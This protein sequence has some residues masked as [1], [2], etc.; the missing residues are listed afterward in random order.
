MSFTRR[1]SLPARSSS[2]GGFTL[3][4]L[5][6]VIGIIALLAGVALG[7]ITGAM[8]T[9]KDNA[10]MQTTHSLYLADFQYSVDNAT[11]GQ[12]ADAADAGFIAQALLNGGYIQD[13]TI[14]YLSGGNAQKWQTAGAA[15]G[16]TKAFV[17]WD[18]MGVNGPAAGGTTPD[19]GVG[20][21]DPDQLPLIWST[22]N[23]INI[24]TG[25]GGVA[26][27]AVVNGAG[28]NPLGTDGI[29]VVFK[30]GSSVFKK[31]TLIG[32]PPTIATFIDA[33]FV[34]A[35]ATNYVVRDGSE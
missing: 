35:N 24:P 19:I 27:T 31:T 8:K 6:V 28:K 34:P 2:R 16:I 13:P 22:G 23:T 32:P 12:F 33:S 11:Q 26:G 21:N 15:A 7:P 17:S 9:A 10:A 3:V 25:Q 1:T 29:P 20:T 14:F 5:L 4:E 30:S 18:F